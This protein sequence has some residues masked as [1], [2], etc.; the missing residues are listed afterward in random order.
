MSHQPPLLRT[1]LLCPCPLQHMFH[2]IKFILSKPCQGDKFD[3]VKC[4]LPG[5]RMQ[6]RG[7]ENG[8]WY[9]ALRRHLQGMYTGWWQRGSAWLFLGFGR[10]YKWTRNLLCAIS[11]VA[12]GWWA[13][14]LPSFNTIMCIKF[15]DTLLPK[16]HKPLMVPCLRWFSTCPA[17]NIATLSSAYM[18]K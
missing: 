17:C 13:G 18:C 16:L 6:G 11:Y 9:G 8:S 15:N 3:G 5:V 7:T 1:V 2:T 10:T 12:V 14:Q 4:V